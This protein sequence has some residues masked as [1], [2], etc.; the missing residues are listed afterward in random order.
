MFSQTRT[1]LQ[2]FDN[3]HD[4]ERMAADILNALG[5]TDVVL[6]APQGGSDEGK[7]ITFTTESGGKGLACVTLRDDIQRKFDEDFKKRKAG[8]YEKY[9]LFCTARLTAKQKLQFAA[10][11]LETLQALFVPYDIEALRSL[12]DSTLKSI[13]ETYLHIKD[14]SKGVSEEALIKLSST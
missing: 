2:Q 8:E 11:C 5:Y 6:I 14:D 12:L 4:F 3:E 13:R 1:A 9:I 10:Y 7:D